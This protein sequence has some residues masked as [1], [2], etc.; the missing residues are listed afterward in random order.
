MSI[1]MI[2][3]LALTSIS[4]SPTLESLR[5]SEWIYLVVLSLTPWDGYPSTYGS[6]A[7]GN[8]VGSIV[9]SSYLCLTES[10]AI[11]E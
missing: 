11:Y 3:R 8:T 7:H 6:V 1:Q 4:T 10:H 5:E 2:D 9:L